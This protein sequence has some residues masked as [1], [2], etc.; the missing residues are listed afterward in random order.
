MMFNKLPS[1]EKASRFWRV[2]G[3]E[4]NEDGPVA[5]FRELS[6]LIWLHRYK[7]IACTAAG[8]VV[9]GLY[10]QSLPR[11][12]VSTATLLLEARQAAIQSQDNGAQQS[13]DLNRADSELQIISSERLLSAV[14]DS[15][16]LQD[17]PEL[18]PQ[19]S[20]TK[21]LLLTSAQSALGTSK[22]DL[23]DQ[24]SGAAANDPQSPETRA[25]QAAF[26]NFGKHLTVRRVGQSYVIEIQ[27]SSVDPALPARVAN[28][29]V[30]AY[31]MQAISFKA[32]AVRTRS[33]ALQ[34][35]LDALGAQVDAAREAMKQ[36]M[37]PAI[38]TPD[39]DARIIGAA[40]PPLQAA[41]PRRTLIAL[42]GGIFGLLAGSSL[43]ALNFA[44]D[45][46]IFNADELT[47]EAGVPCFGFVPGI[48]YDGV[49]YSSDPQQNYAAS[50]RDLRTSI[51]IACSALRTERG[52]IVALIGWNEGIAVS[53]LCSSLSQMIRGGSREVTLFQSANWHNRTGNKTDDT[54][55]NSLADAALS[56]L[57][58]EQLVFETF[59]GVSVLPI[60]S[61]SASANLFADFRHPRVL[62]LLNAVREKGDIIL[63]LPPIENSKDA[64]ALATHADAVLFVATM[65]KTS[66]GQVNSSIEQLKRARA[67]IIG[68][69]MIG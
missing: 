38:P 25:R 33:E 51:E 34:G 2:N 61:G 48:K 1:L 27:Y 24:R 60:Q 30:S 66:V 18:G 54:A 7:L 44:R 6:T 52:V 5:L 36:G 11:T 62:R 40:L 42:L 17:S 65:G 32:D 13:I 23:A 12:Y 59:R 58:P 67:K 3:G 14:F 69:V 56:D 16:G 26:A 19:G 64:L 39:A 47:R 20:S 15:L 46:I 28:A 22:P 35:R 49:A 29:A 57:R 41:G 45:R 4:D 10:A 55:C 50:I 37:L 31:I 21:A 53:A 68:T 63:D 43:V 8:L 9:A